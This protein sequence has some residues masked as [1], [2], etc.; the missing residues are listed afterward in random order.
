MG[1]FA[2]SKEFEEAFDMFDDKKTG[3]LSAK[4]CGNVMRSL[5]QCV[6][7]RAAPPIFLRVV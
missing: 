1:T 3:S 6:G 4:V 7:F 5:G 2:R